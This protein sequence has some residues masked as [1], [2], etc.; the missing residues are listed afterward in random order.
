[1]EKRDLFVIK[2]N[3]H[4]PLV[5]E[6]TRDF[7]N[8]QLNSIEDMVAFLAASSS[9]VLLVSRDKIVHA[10]LSFGV[11]N[12]SAHI[13]CCEALENPPRRRLKNSSINS[14][15]R[16]IIICLLPKALAKAF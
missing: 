11:Y 5:L 7:K 8:C 13:F 2:K 15:M 16:V 14:F 10:R 12:K 4:F 9:M 1:M 3:H 6:S